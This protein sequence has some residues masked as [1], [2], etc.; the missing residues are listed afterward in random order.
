VGTLGLGPEGA[1]YLE[2]GL[3]SGVVETIFSSRAPSTRRYFDLKWN[4]FPLG[5]ESVRWT[6]VTVS[7]PQCWSSSKIASQG[8]ED[9]TCGSYRSP[10]WD[11]AVVLEG[12]VKAC[13]P[14]YGFQTY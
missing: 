13:W 10:T 11:L 6:Q 8:S 12:L 3:S 9:E 1:Q 5:A 4:V 7:W 2:A 14:V